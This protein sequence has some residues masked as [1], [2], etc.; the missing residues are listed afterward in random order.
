MTAK[1]HVDPMAQPRF[2]KPRSVPF[3]MKG[4]VGLELGH[5]QKKGIIEPI[6]FSD[7]EAPIVP[8][9]K[10]DGQ[11]RICVDYKLTVNQAEKLDSYPIAW[12]E[13]L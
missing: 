4:K 7:W 3:A 12:I 13:D 9:L 2:V 10:S 1:I 11:V 6:E 5:L 8:V